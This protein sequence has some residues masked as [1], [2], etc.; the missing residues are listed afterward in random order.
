M[1]VAGTRP[2]QP[3]GPPINPSR[4]VSGA[5]LLSSHVNLAHPGTRVQVQLPLPLPQ[6]ILDQPKVPLV[7]PA[8]LVE[9]LARKGPEGWPG[10]LLRVS[11]GTCCGRDPK[12]EEARGQG[13][14]MVGEGGVLPEVWRGMLGD[15]VCRG[16]GRPSGYRNTPWRK[17]RVDGAVVVRPVEGQCVVASLGNFTR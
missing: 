10:V 13:A 2:S 5:Q 8:V 1:Q 4:T 17:R 11:K 9:G 6:L 14:E 16:R 7:D 3:F 12:V 15:I